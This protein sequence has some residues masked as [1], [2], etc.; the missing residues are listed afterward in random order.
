MWQ[1][2]AALS[3]RGEDPVRGVCRE[4][5]LGG[6]TRGSDGVLAGDIWALLPP[7]SGTLMM[8][9]IIGVRGA[10]SGLTHCTQYAANPGV[11]IFRWLTMPFWDGPRRCDD[12]EMADHP[13][14]GHPKV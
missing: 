5:V 8:W 12:F 4:E 2:D 6:G 11:S 3:S 14:L 10:G 1:Q 7:L 9:V 13:I